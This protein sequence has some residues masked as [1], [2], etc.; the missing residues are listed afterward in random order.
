MRVATRQNRAKARTAR[1]SSIPAPVRGWNARDSIAAM[2]PD[3]AVVLDN[4][5]PTAADIILRKGSDD[6]ATGIDDGVDP[7][8]VETLAVY[9]PP[10][11]T[12]EFFAWAD[13]SIFDVSASGAVGVAVVT[14]LTNARWQQTNFT[15]A[16]GNFLIA[17]NGA[18]DLLLYDGSTW[19]PIDGAST[20]SITNVTTADL[21]HVNS[22]KERVWYIEKDTLDAWYTAAG[23]FAGALTKFPLGGVFKAGG[24]LMAMGTWTIDGGAG[25]DD[26]AVFVSSEGEVA[27]YQ[28][29]NPASSTTWA[30]IG[31]Y[32][33]GTPIGRRCL[34]KLG[35]DLLII[36][37]DGVISASQYFVTARTDKSVAI[38]DRI[39][40]AMADAVGLYSDNF[41]WELGFYP[42]GSMLL[43][44][45][46]KMSGSTVEHQQFVMN[47][48]T[49]AWCRFTD[50]PASCFAV[51]NDELYF[52][53]LGE[54]RKAWTGT[55]DVGEEIDSE[56][57]QA[58]S[59]F[60]NRNRQKHFRMVRPILGW[61]INP[62]RIRLGIDVDFQITTPTGEISPPT[63][64]S[65]LIWDVGQWDVNVWG[66][67]VDL[68]KDWY[69][70]YGIGFAGALHMLVSSSSASMRY[71]SCD[72]LW[73]AGE[74]I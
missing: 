38:T 62:A 9:K 24:F 54:V 48:I 16:G 17:V 22:H 23:A 47:T 7:T 11:G 46:P 49:R 70:V 59:Y 32:T 35:G 60:G 12:E 67:D 36:T 50:W 68:N 18:D 1:T 43:L 20:P 40:T 52:G 73:E 15:T 26:M 3:E 44:N 45:V 21:I 61:D 39:Q 58:F 66:G 64:S 51:Y 29:T 74:V 56:V 34:Q 37:T 4:W 28:G 25:V 31:V 55:S 30:L 53:M 8:T 27:A 6:F 10:S 63:D 13:D 14:G 65:V 33:V 42:G 41:G 2:K 19:T 72:F 71:S 69:S 5:F 57:L